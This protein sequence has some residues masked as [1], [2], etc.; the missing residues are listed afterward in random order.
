MGSCNLLYV[1]ERMNFFQLCLPQGNYLEIVQVLMRVL[2]IRTAILN[3]NKVG[4][5]DSC[6]GHTLEI[7]VIQ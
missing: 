4:K 7:K 5:M 1:W 3:F 2:H 6:L